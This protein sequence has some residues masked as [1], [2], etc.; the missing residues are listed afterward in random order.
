MNESVS[1]PAIYRYNQSYSATIS[2]TPA[3]GVSLGEAIKEMDGI[4]G[5]IL[6]C[7]FQINPGRTK[8]RFYRKQLEPDLR[9]H[10]CHHPDLSGTGGT[11]RKP[12]RSIHLSC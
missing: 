12:D 6:A 7:R 8:P 4:A 10:L 1:P 5:K 9:F 3:P 11:I 2:A